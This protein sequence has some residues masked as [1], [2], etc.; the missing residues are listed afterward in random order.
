MQW[1]GAPEAP[2]TLGPLSFP[3]LVPRS[4]S[5][6]LFVFA[7][8]FKHVPGVCVFTS[9]NHYIVHILV[10]PIVP[11]V[12]AGMCACSIGAGKQGERHSRVYL[13]VI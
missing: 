10:V 7:S 13:Q 3:L 8:S 9:Q 5:F 2:A 12:R 6:H 11:E 1:G 4:L